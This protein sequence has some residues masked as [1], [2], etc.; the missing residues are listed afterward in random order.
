MLR[1]LNPQWLRFDQNLK[2]W[3][4][5]SQDGQLE[6][7]PGDGRWVLVS[8]WSPGL[9]AGHVT[10]LGKAW[11]SKQLSEQDWNDWNDQAAFPIGLCRTPRDATPEE[12][13]QFVSDVYASHTTKTIKLPQGTVEGSSYDYEQ[14]DA[15]AGSS[16]WQSFKTQVEY[17]DRKFQVAILGG[18]LSSEVASS[19]GNR[20]ASATH[21][22]V[23][24][25]LV[26][27]DAQLLSTVIR[28]QV[29][30]PFIEANLGLGV[31]PPWPNWD[32]KEP[33]DLIEQAQALNGFT[34]FVSSIPTNFTVSNLP[35]IAER[36]GVVLVEKT[37]VQEGPKPT[38][39]PE[40]SS[41]GTTSPA[42]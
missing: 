7:T 6:V 13:D 17:V 12:T 40:G 4:Y 27:G 19:G 25:E 2:R 1:T 39:G 38:Q 23:E 37:N 3:T 30:R 41:E 42:A 28:D 9:P 36:F 33:D 24:R 8:R 22:G 31:A 21:H 32:I 14:L 10:S 34:Q 35:D 16:N 26:Q 15:S 18:N 11:L 29:I 20:A 5:D